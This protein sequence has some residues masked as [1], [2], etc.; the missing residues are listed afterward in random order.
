MTI[1]RYRL[2]NRPIP[3]IGASLVTIYGVQAFLHKMLARNATCKWPLAGKQ[4]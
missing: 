4:Q 3:I 1:G 2:N